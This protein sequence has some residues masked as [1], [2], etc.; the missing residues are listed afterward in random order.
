MPPSFQNVGSDVLRTL[1]RI[2]RQVADLRGRLDRGP[3]RVQ[4]AQAG[5]AHC[6]EQVAQAKAALDVARMKADRKQLD[7]KA[8]EDKIQELKTKLNAAA[9]N[10]EYRIFQESIAAKEMA[11]SVLADEVLEA[12][13]AIDEYRPKIDEAERNLAA[14][15]EKAAQVQAQCAEEE[16]LMR[17]DLARVEAEL[18]ETEAALPSEVRDLYRRVVRQR[19]EDAL[20]AVEGEYCGGCRQHVPLNVCNKVMMGEPMFCRSCGRMLYVPEQPA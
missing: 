14:A 11:N 8:G 9:S 4:A 1:H 5:V 19:G 15:R 3:K 7:L 20:A 17:A 6:R 13:M 10:T 16:P 2:H 18:K 12:L